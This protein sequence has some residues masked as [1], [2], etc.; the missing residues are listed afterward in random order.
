MSCVSA[1]LSKC[2]SSF[3]TSCIYLTT[4]LDILL[5]ASKES[6]ELLPLRCLLAVQKDAHLRCQKHWL[7]KLKVLNRQCFWPLLAGLESIQQV[8][9]KPADVL[10][11]RQDAWRK[12]FDFIVSVKRSLASDSCSPEHA[13]M[14]QLSNILAKLDVTVYE[15]PKLTACE[16]SRLDIIYL[17]AEHSF[18]D[19][20]PC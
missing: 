3:R 11:C 4:H 17:L 6:F 1:I 2:L 8:K 15:P 18:D 5:Q 12:L 19:F 14:K 16:E 10:A 20:S 9:V 13:V 7:D